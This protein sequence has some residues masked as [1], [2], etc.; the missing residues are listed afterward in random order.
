MP[1]IFLT[2]TYYNILFD[3]QI[4]K[5]NTF[6]WDYTDVLVTR[7][8]ATETEQEDAVSNLQERF[9][10]ELVDSVIERRKANNETLE[11][12]AKAYIGFPDL[13]FIS[14]DFQEE[15]LHRFTEQGKY[16]P[17]SGFSLSSIFAIRQ[18]I[19]IVDIKTEE[20]KIRKDAYK[21]FDNLTNPKNII[22]LITPKETFD[23]PD[24]LAVAGGEPLA[25][26]E[27]SIIEPSLL[28][29]IN[30]MSSDAK[31]RFRLD[32]QPTLL[33]FMPTGGVGTNIFYLLCAWASLLMTHKWWRENYE[34]ACIVSEENIG[35]DAVGE[36]VHMELQA[37]ENIHIISKN[38]KASI[39]S[40]ERKLHCQSSPKGLLVLAGEKLSM[41]ISLP[42]TDV[43]FLFNEK[44]SPD[45]I[46][47]KMYRALTPSPGK[48]SAFIVD[49]NPVRTLA[50]LYGY[51]RASHE[52]SNTASQ[53]LDI[54]YDT[55]SWDSDIF[56]YN[57][58]KGSDAKPLSFQDKLRQLFEMAEKDPSNEYRINEDI[59]G[60]EKKLGDNIRRGMDSE[61]VSK[62]AGQFSSKKLETTLGSIGLK[63]G[64]K[65][66]LENGR[67]IIR[68]PKEP[69]EP[70]VA[71]IPGEDIEIVIDNFIETIADFVKYLAITS[72]ASTL[73]GALEEY[74]SNITNQEGSSLR[75]NVLRLV[76]SRTEI[77]EGKDKELL[78]KLLIAAVKDFA[79]NSSERVFR[80]MKGKIDEKSTRKDAVLKII[81]KYLTPRKKQKEEK[82]EVFTPVELIESMLSHLPD[83]IW[84]NP[85]LKWLDPANGI[86]NFPVVAFYKLNEGLK[87]W[88]QNDTKRRKH[89]INNMLYMLE[90]QSNN[91][92]IARN[93]FTKLCEGCTPNIMSTNS[94]EMTSA[95]L[96]AKGWP[97]K[98]DIVMGNPPFNAGG[99]LKGGGTLW[100][101]FVKLAFDLVASN[102][103]ISFVHPPGWRKFY[104]PED[105]ENQGKI[106]FDIRE[107]GWNLDYI[108]VSDQ[109]PKHFPIVDY[110]VI[111]AKKSD[112]ITKYDSTF[113]GIVGKGEA[114]LD[115]PFIPNMLNDDTLSILK[116]LF[117]A[118]G[119]TIDIV[120]N[121][122]FKP[123]VSDKGKSGIPHYHFTSRTGEKQIYNKE[124]TSIPEYINKDKVIMTYNGGYEKG[125]LFSFYSDGKMGTTN[126]SMYMLTKSKAQGDKL[127][128]FFNSDIITFLMKITQYSPSPNHKN[129]FKILNQLKMPDSLDYGLT[130][131]ETELIKRVVGAK[132]KEEKSTEGGGKQ[133]RFTR[134]VRRV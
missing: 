109:P 101:K 134:K 107:K 52:S 45:D 50:A 1:F 87:S 127:V 62:I 46:I 2:A 69:V 44:K 7:S 88:E 61:F 15:A 9:G 6:I 113:M 40:L 64:S 39:L 43:V 51:T 76:H 105:R 80:Q 31:S 26:E 29:R 77:K 42:C 70:Q 129:E 92:R 54:I 97:E 63:E 53:I 75:Q 21:I 94:L 126:N 13:F 103:Y 115:Y 108:N 114:E 124:Y 35:A 102:G 121:Q 98:Y 99:L 119:E 24:I 28:G 72:T 41:G 48:K 125:R 32:E 49:L 110:Y 79:F 118:D 22:S 89:I 5:A 90:L 123:S 3:Y 74:E 37:S 33:M 116:K 59:G 83:S 19:T 93:I 18:G 131:K 106:W 23:I 85:E 65:V 38:P 78:S 112:A 60:F 20:N 14:A 130:A 67:L 120:Y 133:R 71:P 25:K 100:P 11:T 91:T 111:H 96:K 66:S 117:K 4:Q 122:S 57:L 30:K 84:K 27:G 56:E 12:M 58:K 47:Q 68:A 132:E 82:G 34:I 55:Y 86:G 104:D 95:K 81:H 16:R 8:L 36:L 73:E 128:K 17:D 10:K